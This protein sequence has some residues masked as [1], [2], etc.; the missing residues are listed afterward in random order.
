[1]RGPPTSLNSKKFG[2][3]TVLHFSHFNASGKSY[4]LC[5]CICGNFHLVARTNL[6]NGHASSCGCYRR[7]DAAKRKPGTK[8]GHT[9]NRRASRTFKSW[10]S[11]R[12]RCENPKSKDFKYYGARGIKIDKRWNNFATFLKDMGERPPGK[13]LNRI[14]NNGP[15]SPANCEWASPK[16]QA[17]NRR[18]GV[19]K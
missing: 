1:M 15:Y 7:E 4:W 12:Y 19:R 13:T 2:R 8:H 6:I 14:D 17:R 9:A 3:L 18:Q 11:M 10:D 16:E 5:E